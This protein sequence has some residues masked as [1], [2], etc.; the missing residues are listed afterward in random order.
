MHF[1]VL[2]ISE[3]SALNATSSSAQQN[4]ETFKGVVIPCCVYL[5][6][7]CALSMKIEDTPTATCDIIS[8]AII[9]CEELGLNKHPAPQ[10]FALWMR[11]PLLGKFL[12]VCWV[13]GNVGCFR[14]AVEAN[15]EAVRD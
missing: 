12:M 2:I 5:H 8:Q 9:S 11:S 15:A 4:P 13:F 7:R 3:A 6:N 10:V 14:V 1:Y